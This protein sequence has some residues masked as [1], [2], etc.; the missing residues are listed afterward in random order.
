MNRFLVI[1]FLFL[2]ALG[3]SQG[4]QIELDL[5]SRDESTGK[6]LPSVTITVY[7]DNQ[8]IKTVNTN[9][10]G[11]ADK[12]YVP[13][14]YYYKIEF[15][16]AGYVS[17]TATL[18]ARYDTPEDLYPVTYR[19][20]EFTLFPEM[21]GVDFSFMENEPMVEFEFTP[22]GS[23]IGWDVDALS[24]MQKKIETLKKEIKEKEKELEEN[25]E[26]F[27]QLVDEA[28]KMYNSGDY[29]QALDTYKTAQSYV[30]D[31]AHVNQR[32]DDCQTKI[33]EIA[34]QEKADQEKKA[35][36]DAL[37]SEADNLYDN[38]EYEAAKAKY[39]EAL[40][41]EP[42]A[43]HPTNRISDIDKLLVQLAEE[44]KNTEAYNALMAEA[45]TLFDQ[46]QYEA[47][48]TKYEDALAKKPSESEPKQKISEI[49]QLLTEQK[50]A[51]EKEQKYQDYMRQGADFYTANNL[52]GAIS[53]Y[54]KAL[55]EK[56]GD[57]DAQQKIDEIQA[58]INEN[59]ALAQQE[60]AYENLMQKAKQLQNAES[61]EEAIAKYNEALKIKDQDA[62]ALNQ[63]KVCEQKI[64][65]RDAALA[66]Q[67]VFDEAKKKADDLYASKKWEEALAAYEAL[68]L[69]KSTTQ[70]QTRISEIK[71]T[72][73][74]QAKN[75][76]IED[77][78]N[79]LVAKAETYENDS[80]LELALETYKQAY[81][82]KSDSAVKAKITEIEQKI[83]QEAQNKSTEEAYQQKMDLANAKFNQSDWVQAKSYYQQALNIK[84]GDAE[85]TQ[86]IEECQ[87]KMDAEAQAATEAE[88]QKVFQQAET[89]FLADNL[90]EA[91]NYYNKALTIRPNDQAAADRLLQIQNLRD[92]RANDAAS[93]N[94][95]DR[96]YTT[97]MDEGKRQYN[98]QNYSA[99]L[100]QYNK[101]LGVKPNDIKALEKINEINDLLTAQ[102]EANKKRLKYETIV[103]EADDFFF[104]KKDWQ[105][106]KAKYE[107]A[108]TLISTETYPKEQIVKCNDLMKGATLT[109][110]EKQYQK[111]LDVAQKSID[112]K[113]Y[114][115]AINLYNRAIKLKPDDT[116]PK[117]QIVKVE[118]M[119]DEEAVEAEYDSYIKKADDLFEK[120]KWDE[121]REY[122]VKAYN[123]FN[124]TWPD[125]QIKIIDQ[126]ASAFLNQQYDKMIVKADEY[127]N[128]K[129][130][131][132][133]IELYNRAIKL[134]PNRD[135]TYAEGRLEEINNILNQ[136]EM[137][138]V[139]IKNRGTAVNSTEEEMDAML[140]DAE[141]QRRYNE[142]NKVLTQNEKLT[143]YK[144]EWSDREVSATIESK[145]LADQVETEMNEDAVQAEIK[146]Q[147]AEDAAREEAQ[148]YHDAQSEIAV[149]T[150]HVIFRN[151]EVFDNI[152]DEI[153]ANQQDAD[154]ARLE[155][156]AKVDKMKTE[157]SNEET[158]NKNDQ[159]NDI[160]NQVDQIDDYKDQQAIKDANM[161][162]ARQNMEEEVVDVKHE[163]SD[164]TNEDK[165]AQNEEIAKSKEQIVDFEDARSEANQQAEIERQEMEEELVDIKDEYSDTQT[166][167][168]NQQTDESFKMKAY[169]E[170]AKEEIRI[171]N[172]ENDAPREKMEGRMEEIQYEVNEANNEYKS[173]QDKATYDSKENID[174]SVDQQSNMFAEKD[175][176]RK[177]DA[178]DIKTIEDEISVKQSNLNADNIDNSHSTQ[179]V[180]DEQIESNNAMKAEGD[181]K[182]VQNQDKTKEVINEMNDQKAKESQ[183]NQ[184][185]VN[186][187]FDKIQE[188]KD[189]DI[190]HVD[191]HVK[192]QLGEKYPEGVTEEIYEERDA[193]GLL[194]AYIV[195]RLVV[196]EGEGNIYEKVKTRYGTSYTKNGVAITQ[197]QWSNDTAN[198]NLVN[199]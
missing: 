170:K 42:K 50:A 143:T 161:D 116:F 135:N 163:I 150:E 61:Y 41:I 195:R 102:I 73:A 134:L 97:Y 107:E 19:D 70:A 103:K 193:N 84:A 180:I 79:D 140:A 174:H 80:N 31:D 78:F 142:I 196:I 120:Q 35:Q 123:L 176:K 197:Y 93:Q 12:F 139:K 30:A 82:V 32:I 2:S 52:N 138:G 172:M 92:Q 184:E 87:Q 155:T 182:T 88:Y 27:A 10:K 169:T 25:A 159:T 152:E 151:Q 166:E 15:S 113:D 9:S 157:I 16:K 175:E 49:D 57:T 109:E 21:E 129:N 34:A 81:I 76:A 59:Q 117:E 114:D 38:K 124:R 153:S 18:D 83:E 58:K 101:A 11:R 104:T 177:Q 147:K 111:I 144:E 121:A 171:Q 71:E 128:K 187:S 1:I 106:A 126:Q 131:D 105:Q 181:V 99:A 119:R 173:G 33:D 36:Y 149:Y 115:K 48:K 127:F 108:L 141:E 51:A 39:Q 90:I 44:E 96:Q 24:E 133:S 20:M 53:S 145:E 162:V 186:Q 13:V 185:K 5:R 164:K 98:A 14:G 77:E 125:E 56:P 47:A 130:Y 7:Q 26:R 158:T 29:Q 67:K 110:E 165:L 146:R 69:I 45:K 68:E 66:D 89:Y 179:A 191:Q 160:Y 167:W 43:A 62:E 192:N 17:K 75:Q 85:A 94:E 156:E 3:W 86:K 122:Y 91:E 132:K 183:E 60:E 194:T 22:D 154:V 28:D 148:D 100:D 8:K 6:P 168:T 40:G 188:L 63:I 95:K 55:N 178:E 54:K 72:L 189:V 198:G 136:P 74:N 64:A 4:P 190:K 46:Q 65:D 137:T 23:T 118:K 37:I 112:K 199:N